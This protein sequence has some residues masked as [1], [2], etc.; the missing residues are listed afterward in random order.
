MSHQNRS[1][2]T[3]SRGGGALTT[4]NNI[5][6]VD[7]S[8]TIV[9]SGRTFA[10]ALSALA[11]VLLPSGVANATLAHPDPALQSVD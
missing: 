3:N 11:A 8:I 6:R 4:P 1:E 2:A 9:G 5:P 7:T 10:S